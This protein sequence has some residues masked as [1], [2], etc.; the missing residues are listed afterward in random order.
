MKMHGIDSVAASPCAHLNRATRPSPLTRPLRYEPAETTSVGAVVGLG[1]FAGVWRWWERN[2]VD[3]G[4]GRR[5]CGWR[6][7]VERAK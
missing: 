5:E 3:G 2:G 7:K 4:V 6:D 1:I